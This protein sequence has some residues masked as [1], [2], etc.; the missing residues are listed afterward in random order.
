MKGVS[1]GLDTRTVTWR[2]RKTPTKHGREVGTIVHRA[3]ATT[4]TNR[5]RSDVRAAWFINRC[6]SGVTSRG[7]SLSVHNA[8]TA[9]AIASWLAGCMVVAALRN[10]RIASPTGPIAAGVE[11]LRT[12]GTGAGMA[13]EA[14]A[15]CPPALP[16]KPG[17]DAKTAS[18]SGT[19]I[20]LNN[21]VRSCTFEHAVVAH[22]SSLAI[23]A[24]HLSSG[25]GG[26]IEVKTPRFRRWGAQRHAPWCHIS[27]IG[28]QDERNNSL[29]GSFKLGDHQMRPVA[30]GAWRRYGK[31]MPH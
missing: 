21:V 26:Q 27:F 24:S 3:G 16:S 29:H 1:S 15:A 7:T 18:R 11:A 14:A 31:C 5:T 20:R 10:V 30:S 25:R 23:P 4:R 6:P 19:P 22:S 8:T 2:A 28:L 13:L 9:S 12:R 17:V